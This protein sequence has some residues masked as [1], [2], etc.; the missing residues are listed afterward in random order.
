MEPTC[1]MKKMLL[2]EPEIPHF[3]TIAAMVATFVM[4]PA[5]F[6]Y[7]LDPAGGPGLLFVT[8]PTILQDMPGGRLFAIA[9]YLAV[10]FGGISS[11]KYVGSC[12]GIGSL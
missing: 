9:L 1:R 6:A 4:I 12:F 2:E 10:V 8:L 7:G 5:C 3:D 11:S